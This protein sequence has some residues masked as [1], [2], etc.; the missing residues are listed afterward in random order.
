MKVSYRWLRDLAPGLELDAPS[1]EHPAF[2]SF[3]ILV[4]L[5]SASVL[6]VARRLRAGRLP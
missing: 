5:S 3:L 2:A 6:L 4:G 1:A